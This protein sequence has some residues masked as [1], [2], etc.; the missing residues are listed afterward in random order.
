MFSKIQKKRKQ[1]DK[2][3]AISN[4]DR[5]IEQLNRSNNNV[6]VDVY[7]FENNQHQSFGYG[8][9]VSKT[10]TYNDIR[11]AINQQW[12]ELTPPKFFFY[13]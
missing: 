6:W 5:V 13:V 8:V 2:Y 4:E 1:T 9:Y 3:P 7:K 12:G 11:Q 10:S